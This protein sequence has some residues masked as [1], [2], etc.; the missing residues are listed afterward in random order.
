VVD[1]SDNQRDERFE[2]THDGHTGDLTYLLNG[3]RITL[4]HTGVPEELEGQGLAGQLVQ[5][6]VDR[7]RRDG[8][9]IVPQ[10]PYARR[11]LRRHESELTDV[12]I[13]WTS[14]PLS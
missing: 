8:L 9:T 13:D 12:P 14:E 1:V 7:A 4:V 11:W 5:A 3:D 10:C 2:V 6:A